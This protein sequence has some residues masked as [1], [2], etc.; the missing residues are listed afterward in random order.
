MITHIWSITLTVSNL[1]RAIQFY[2]SKLGLVK[3]YQFRDY[4]GFDCG[5]PEVGLKTWGEL[6]PPREGEPC[7]DLAVD[8]L[9]EAYEVLSSRG[10]EFVK[11]PEDVQWGARTAICKDPD[12]NTLQLTQIDWKRYFSCLT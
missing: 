10:V 8:N 4:A 3:K 11:Q 5:G 7:L 9:D 1:E 12:G 6:Q 2:E